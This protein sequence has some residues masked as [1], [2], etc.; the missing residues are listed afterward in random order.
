VFEDAAQAHGA[1]WRGRRTGALGTAAAFSFYPS[2][3]LGALGDGGAICTN[4]GAI[5]DEARSLRHLGQRGKGHHE[6]LGYNERLDGLQAGFLRVKLRHL[7]TWN[8]ARRRHAAAYCEALQG[9]VE[10]LEEHQEG[11]CVYHVYPVRLPDRD[12]AAAKLASAGIHTGV[13]YSP[14]VPDQPPFA[15]DSP[16]SG[17]PRARRWASEELS[18]PMFEHLTDHELIRVAEALTAVIDRQRVPD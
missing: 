15:T 14:A 6:R 11:V 2:K 5:A 4:D 8:A 1:T 7:D 18:L 3:N 12:G 10:L 13:H 17:F 9:Q 16:A